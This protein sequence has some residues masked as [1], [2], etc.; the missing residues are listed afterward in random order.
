VP[1]ALS[2]KD[3]SLRKQRAEPGK[4]SEQYS[5]AFASQSQSLFEVSF[6]FY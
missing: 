1:R 4:K 2:Q 6:L 5:I 3:Q